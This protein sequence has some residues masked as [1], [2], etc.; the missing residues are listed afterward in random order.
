MHAASWRT[1]ETYLESTVD[2]VFVGYS[3]PSADFEFRDLLKRVQ[4][5]EKTRPN[6]TVILGGAGADATI[7]RFKKFF[8][9]VPQERHF[10]TGGLDDYALAHLEKIQVLKS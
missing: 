9:D 2:W 3:M 6:I 1:A 8:G 10:L 5:T 4:L 7:T